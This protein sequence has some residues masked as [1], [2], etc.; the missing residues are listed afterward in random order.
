M[1]EQLVFKIPDECDNM[2]ALT[3]LKERCRLSSRMIT[4]LKR[5]KDGI[6]M[7]GKI[8]RT[9]DFVKSGAEVIIN[10]PDENSAIHPVEGTLDIA[11]EDEHLLIVNKPPSMPVHPVKQHQTD[12]LANIVSFYAKSKGESYVFRA[13]N[14]LD[15]DTSGLV[16]I[17][18]NRYCANVMKNSVEKTYYALCH[19]KI[20]NDGTVRA[21]IGLR[22]DSKMVRCVKSKG[23]DAVTHY[24]VISSNDLISFIELFLETGKTHQIRCHMAFLG[25]PLLGDDLYGG[26]LDKIS[27]Q[28]LHCGQ[29]SFRH[30]VTGEQI[31]VTAQIPDDMMK[32][33]KRYNTYRNSCR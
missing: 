24:K 25:H 27:R 2:K 13:L 10:L 18:K 22:E 32:L 15:K 17:V 14:R 6:L 33:I 19:G 31:T 28:A 8:L 23:A 7:D 21:P 12:T 11:Y 9:V 3:F 20:E 30:P 1:A 4:R 16:V 29:I 26:S 5:E